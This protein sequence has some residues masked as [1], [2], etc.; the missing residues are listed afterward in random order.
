MM[1]K[2]WEE[3]DKTYGY[4]PDSITD[5][6][7]KLGKYFLV[8]LVD[9]E[10]IGFVIGKAHKKSKM[11]VF[12]KDQPYLEIEDIYIKPEKRNDDFGGILLEKLIDIAKEEG[13]S[14][15]YIYSSV[16]DLDSVQR[17]YKKHG[18]QNWSMTMFRK[19]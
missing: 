8:G 1:Q 15:Y 6:E 17:F 3:N 18:F 12:D 16:K 4:T 9:D 14:N 7:D 11:C 10:L 19:D 13:I 5:L 2:S